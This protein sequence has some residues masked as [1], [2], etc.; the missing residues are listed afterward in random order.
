MKKVIAVMISL[1]FVMLYGCS[2]SGKISNVSVDYEESEIY[3]QQDI[4]S[5]ID[6]IKKEL[7]SFEGCELYLITYLGDDVCKDNINH[8]SE[9]QEGADFN[10]CIVF[11][12][13]FHSPQKGWGGWE[14]DSEY[15]W[16]W[17]LARK[18]SDS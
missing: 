2:G 15:G 5:A 3:S 13:S 4:N 14:P 16:N 8:C 12:S 9:L 18:D 17:Y 6:V 1:C 7:S 11:K 10:E